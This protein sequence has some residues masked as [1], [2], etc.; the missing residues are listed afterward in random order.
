MSSIALYCNWTEIYYGDMA[1]K[2]NIIMKKV[3]LIYIIQ[4]QLQL[5][6]I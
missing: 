3:V 1:T 4:E 6:G 2:E 5:E